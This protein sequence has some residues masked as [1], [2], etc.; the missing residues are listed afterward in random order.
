MNMRLRIVT[1]TFIAVGILG[2]VFVGKKYFQKKS[3]VVMEMEE[4]L[5][6]CPMHPAITSK[7]PGHCPICHMTLQKAE[8]KPKT[9]EKK[10]SKKILFY[11]HP[12]RP[13]ITSPTPNKDEMGMD[14]I[15]VYDEETTLNVESQMPGRA[16]FQLPQNQQKLIGVTTTKVSYQELSKEIRASGRVAF[17]P[18]LFSAI[19]EYRQAV[20]AAKEMAKSTYAELREEA[21]S[22]V[23][24]SETR[25]KLLGLSESQIEA[26]RES[27][28]SSMN[29][30]LPKGSVWIYAEVF[31][32]EIGGLKTGQKVSVWAPAVPDKRFEGQI[33]SIRPVLNAPSRTFRIRAEVTDLEGDLRPD[34]FVNV[35]IQM[36]FGKKIVVPTDAI[37]HSGDQAF[38][39][40]V[41]E[42][43][44]FEP[45]SVV[46]GIKANKL[47]EIISGVN[48]N[49]EVVTAANFL[50]D[51][52]SR[53][54]SAIGKL[55]KAPSAH[56]EHK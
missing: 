2:G 32:F 24:S 40:V 27:K 31:E 20:E 10:Q 23:A 43:G 15:P 12:M 13:D 51:S 55:K 34:T 1:I 33:S 44:I 42:K 29:L 25:L 26:V 22:L 52:E 11:R 6:F 16:T 47:T 4:E 45:R 56:G 35:K 41:K 39:F 50:I 53:L 54:R 5:Y 18:E 36:T 49:E 30:L 48:E 7:V 46:T 19:E 17:D 14:Y 3:G 8:G 37:L 38:L 21:K 9:P 28:V